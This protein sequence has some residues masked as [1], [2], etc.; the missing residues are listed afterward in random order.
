MHDANS[1]IFRVLA[2]GGTASLSLT[3][4]S[5]ERVFSQLDLPI[6]GVRPIKP[7]QR[8][9]FRPN[10]PCETQEPPNMN[11]PGASLAELGAPTPK[12]DPMAQARA[13]AR[14]YPLIAKAEERRDRRLRRLEQVDTTATTGSEHIEQSDEEE[15][16]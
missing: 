10:I 4:E 1:P 12:I 16:R 13:W 14:A 2:G 7:A 6:E 8:P 5:G 15:Q 11:A 3:N 9:V